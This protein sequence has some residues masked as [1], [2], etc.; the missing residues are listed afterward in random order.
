MTCEVAV[1]NKLGVALAAD[2]VVTL[3]DGPKTYH[4]AEKLF[5]LSPVAPVGIMT[6]GSAEMMG[7]PWETVIKIYSQQ[8]GARRFDRLEQYAQDLLRFIEN[9]ES[10]FPE[11]AQRQWFRSLVRAYW[12]GEFLE[13]LK[14][15]I[16]EKPQSR[17][18][19]NDILDGLVKKDLE[20]WKDF[21]TIE[22]L[23]AAYG[24]RI[25]AEYD[26]ILA[27]IEKELFGAYS[28]SK[29]VLRGLRTIV[30]L[31]YTQNWFHLNDLTGVVVAGMGE[32]EPFPVLQHYHVGTVAAG[33]LRFLKFDDAR[34]SR[35]DTSS[36][37]PLAQRSMIDLFYCGIYPALRDRLG[38]IIRESMASALTAKGAKAS[39]KLLSQVEKDFQEALK[40]EVDQ[41]YTQP[42]VAA[43]AALPRHELATM[44]EALVSLTAFR[45]RM[46]IE[47]TE[48][49]GGPIDVAVISKGEGFVWVKRKDLVKPQ[50]TVN[51]L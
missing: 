31:M 42:L 41:K 9:A 47:E 19:A 14:K 5:P 6:Y 27:D 40:K 51:P 37:V 11:S 33:R 25:L 45:A 43:V 13:P 17:K 10:L 15:E 32:S 21:H 46:S 34:V 36:V 49:V 20:W 38:E 12:S 3:G 29:D 28:I 18:R 44:A 16:E 7:L 4:N 50:A 48:T 23:G 22:E 26:S 2:S 30:R 35:E 24:D 8:L 1:M 39:P